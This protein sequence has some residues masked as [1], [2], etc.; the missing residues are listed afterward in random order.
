M[1]EL[2][3][4]IR[5]HLRKGF[6]IPIGFENGVPAEIAL[7]PRAFQDL[8]MALSFKELRLVSLGVTVRIDTLG[9]GRS[10]LKTIQ[11]VT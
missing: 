3:L 1:R 9:V 5:V 2:I 7:T 4:D 10:V 8:A 11:E 6:I